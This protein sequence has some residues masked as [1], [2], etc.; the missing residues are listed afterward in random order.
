MAGRQGAL[1][2]MDLSRSFGGVYSGCRV[3]VTGH[4]GFKGS[5]LAFWLHHLGARVH[6]LALDPG[7]Q[8][9]HWD[10]LGLDIEESRID[11]RDARAVH[12]AVRRA[13]PEIVFHLGAQALVRRSYADPVET[14]STNVIGLVNLLEALRQSPRVRAVV[15]ATTDKCYEN[16]GR[17]QGYRE[18][19]PLGGYD[20]YSAS[21][22]CAEIVS[23][24]WRRSFL[25]HASSGRILLATARAGNV[26]GGGDW[27][28]DRLVPDLVRGA[29]AGK[30]T[31][32][33]CPAAVRPW[34]HV[35]DPL[36]GYLELGRRLLAGDLQA[37]GAWNFG[38]LPEHALSVEQ[39]VRRLADHWPEISAEGDGRP[40]PHEEA[41]LTLD[42]RKARLELGWEPVWSD[43]R[44]WRRTALW[45]Q[46]HAQ[47]RALQTPDDLQ[48]FVADAGSAGRSWCNA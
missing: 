19:D 46:A 24:S 25:G 6:G 22:A 40:H 45:Y 8:P 2:E 7:T 20:P 35:L 1:E 26:V 10:L 41:A 30:P 31:P 17:L 44:L 3:L 4:T 33:R 18:V 13:D 15:N 29:V 47:G 32:V 5:W 34:Q 12:E 39:V 48:A 43:D 38:P 36:S 21:K 23:A 37:Q 28:A 11:L 9:C 42:C 14:F 16:D 27:A